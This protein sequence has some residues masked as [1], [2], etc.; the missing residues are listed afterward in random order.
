MGGRGCFRNPN[1]ISKDCGVGRD[2]FLRSVSKLQITCPGVSPPVALVTCTRS[3]RSPL[4]LPPP[5]T[6]TTHFHSTPAASLPVSLTSTLA[7]R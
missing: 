4:H 1:E 7:K 3:S 5:P 2:L 6:T